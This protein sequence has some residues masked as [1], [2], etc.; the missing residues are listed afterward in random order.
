MKF[1][2]LIAL[3]FSTQALRADDECQKDI[4]ILHGEVEKIT[5]DAK[6]HNANATEAALR[7]LLKTGPALEK[8]CHLEG[9]CLNDVKTV[10]EYA[11][12]MLRETEAGNWTESD[13]D[14]KG[15]LQAYEKAHS[16]CRSPG[17]TPDQCR[18]DLFNIEVDYRKLNTSVIAHNANAT[19]AELKYFMSEVTKLE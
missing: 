19:E 6:A 5:E 3:I 9:E 16:D 4:M 13:E 12:K 1:L 8:V 11:T 7:A 17:P 2:L 10:N 18:Q 15:M 14:L